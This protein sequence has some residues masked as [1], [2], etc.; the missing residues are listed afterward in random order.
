MKD[1]SESRSCAG[2]SEV[3]AGCTNGREEREQLRKAKSITHLVTTS[4]LFIVLANYN[5]SIIV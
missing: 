5:L 3:G 4:I 1:G 2:A